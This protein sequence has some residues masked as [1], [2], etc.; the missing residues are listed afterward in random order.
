[1]S[2]ESWDDLAAQVGGLPVTP[3][4]ERALGVLE[5]AQALEGSERADAFERFHDALAAAL[6]EEPG[7]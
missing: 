1:M 3:S 7:T 2:H 5:E 6:D 4:V